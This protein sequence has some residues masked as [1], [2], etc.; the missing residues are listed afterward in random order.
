MFF[1]RLVAFMSHVPFTS[2]PKI[3]VL[4]ALLIII[5]AA[6]VLSATGL[7]ISWWVALTLVLSAALIGGLGSALWLA[8]KIGG[9]D[10]REDSESTDANPDYPLALDET[11]R[12]AR[13]SVRQ[14]G[15]V[16]DHLIHRMIHH[17][18]LD[19]ETH[20]LL[21]EMRICSRRVMQ[22]ISEPDD[23]SL[24]SSAAAGLPYPDRHADHALERISG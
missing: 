8:P 24:R 6:P 12:E 19:R 18:T 7:P 16:E 4:V 2:Y 20:R 17:Y 23:R 11:L 9:A 3:L 21:T 13:R 14:L 1:D 15:E 22:Q 10:R 5:S